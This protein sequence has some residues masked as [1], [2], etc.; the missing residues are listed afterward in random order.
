MCIFEVL[1]PK[2]ITLIYVLFL[3]VPIGL[4]SLIAHLLSWF[5]WFFLSLVH[6]TYF[7]PLPSHHEAFVYSSVGYQLHYLCHSLYCF[8]CYSL[9][10]VWNS[11]HLQRGWLTD[12]FKPAFFLNAFLHFQCGGC[13]D[14]GETGWSETEEGH[15]IQKKENNITSPI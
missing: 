5:W 14:A 7:N 9:S 8:W 4:F 3:F 1:V 11:Y 12:P 2:C 13:F 10:V 15:N 6:P